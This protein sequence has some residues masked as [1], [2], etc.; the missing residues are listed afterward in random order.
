MANRTDLIGYDKKCLIRPS[1]QD[2][3][4][5]GARPT[6]SSNGHKNTKRKDGNGAGKKTGNKGSKRENDVK[7]SNKGKIRSLKNKKKK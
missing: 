6:S 7:A 4:K 5:Y 2:K 3:D 1:Y